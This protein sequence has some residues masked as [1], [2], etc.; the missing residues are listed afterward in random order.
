MKG[1]LAHV[2]CDSCTVYC[3]I[4]VNIT[5]Y[6]TAIL[7][8]AVEKQL[9]KS[10]IQQAWQP[11]VLSQHGIS[12]IPPHRTFLHSLY[13]TAT[14]ES[15]S[16]AAAQHLY[17]FLIQIGSKAHPNSHP[18]LPQT[19]SFATTH[20]LFSST[21]LHSLHLSLYLRHT[22]AACECVTNYPRHCYPHRSP[23]RQSCS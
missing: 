11:M 15:I 19:P 1:G 13:S 2:Q 9:N 21:S 23:A 17:P 20:S 8:S 22:A 10:H 5:I 12:T 7:L 4:G 6:D 16:F 14:I 18:F 3:S